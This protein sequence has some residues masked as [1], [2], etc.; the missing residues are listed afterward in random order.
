MTACAGNHA[1][2]CNLRQETREVRTRH[3]GRCSR[4]LVGG[5]G[6]RTWTSDSSSMPLSNL[7]GEVTA[8]EPEARQ[9]PLPLREAPNEAMGLRSSQMADKGATQDEGSDEPLGTR[10]D[11]AVCAQVPPLPGRDHRS[12]ECELRSNAQLRRRSW[13]C[14]SRI[15]DTSGHSGDKDGQRGSGL[16]N[17]S[18]D[19]TALDDRLHSRKVRERVLGISLS[20][21]QPYV[22]TSEGGSRSA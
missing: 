12:G 10:L 14:I 2:P 7:S 13:R 11:Q 15:R 5:T 17:E 6:V 16:E 18:M 3:S 8:S 1:R 22:L 21:L 9:V 19:S 20:D 4:S